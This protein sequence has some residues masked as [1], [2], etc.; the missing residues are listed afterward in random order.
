MVYVHRLLETE[1]QRLQECAKEQE[2]E[3]RRQVEELKKDNNRQ[4]KLIGQVCPD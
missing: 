4:Q 1:I 3:F 2:K